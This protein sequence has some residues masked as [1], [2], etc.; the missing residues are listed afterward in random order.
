MSTHIEARRERARRALETDHIVLIGAGSHIPV[1]G[2]MDRIYPFKPHPD[3]YWLTG[4]RTPGAVLAFDPKDGWRDFTPDLT[5]DD[6]V[7]EGLTQRAGEPISGLKPWLREREGRPVA[8]LGV[9]GGPLDGVKSDQAAAERYT[10]LLLQTRRSKDDTEIALMK[11]A[12]AATAAGFARA[13]EF[14]APGVTE[15]AIQI[16]LEAECFRSGGQGMGYDAIVGTGTNAAILHFAPSGRVVKEGDFVLIDAGCEIDGYTA[17]VTRTFV[18]GTPSQQQTELHGIVREALEYG[19]SQCIPGKEWRELHLECATLMAKGLVSLG[20]LKGE[21]AGLVE[22]DAHAI[23]FPHGLGHLVGLGVRDGSG[24]MP[25]RERS[26]RF[27]LAFLRMDLP[28]EPGFITTVEPGLYFIEPLL[29][30]PNRREQFADCIDWEEVDR[31]LHIG[32]VRLE[33][34]LL[35]TDN[36]PVNLTHAIPLSL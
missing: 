25:G 2:G 18:V 29:S 33:D 34:N 26:D 13:R 22:R 27:G 8:V 5:E 20:I 30:D 9:G 15:R 11:R 21:P 17:D 32:G 24:Y 1:P 36:K 4:H 28:L 19:N 14:A 31:W 3:H 23:F 16:E 10:E 35:V 12:C 7:W 6:H